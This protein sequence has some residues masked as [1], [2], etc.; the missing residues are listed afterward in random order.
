MLLVGIKV[1]RPVSDRSPSDLA[2][3]CRVLSIDGGSNVTLSAWYCDR[4]KGTPLVIQFHGYGAEKTCL[5]R[6]AKEF[7][8]AGHE[9]YASMYPDEWRAA[10]AKVMKTAENKRINETTHSSP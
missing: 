1:P 3:D 8:S 9:G 4:G 5:L 6:E 10:V 2:P 7:V